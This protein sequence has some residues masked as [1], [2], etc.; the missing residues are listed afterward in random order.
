MI[1]NPHFIIGPALGFCAF[2]IGVSSMN[3]IFFRPDETGQQRFTVGGF[4]DYLKLPFT[5]D[6]IKRDIAW[7]LSNNVP[8]TTRLKMLNL[9]WVAMVGTGF[10]CSVIYHNLLT[11]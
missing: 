4:I 2:L 1:D 7:G 6:K 3:G 11:M 10:I 8:I 5:S 9:N